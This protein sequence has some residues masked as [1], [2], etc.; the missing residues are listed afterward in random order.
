MEKM[1][2]HMCGKWKN[3]STKNTMTKEIVFF[4][5]TRVLISITG[6][7]I[8]HMARTSG[9]TAGDN[10]PSLHVLNAD[11]LSVSLWFITWST[12]AAQISLFVFVHVL[13][14]LQVFLFSSPTSTLV[15]LDSFSLLPSF[16]SHTLNFCWR[17]V[18]CC[19]FN[20]IAVSLMIHLVAVS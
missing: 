11:C 4:V 17:Q 10:T 5:I 15:S 2:K 1:I 19:L 14:L 7:V 6:Y 20:L 16:S 12:S 3:K 18:T 9:P 8:I 13:L